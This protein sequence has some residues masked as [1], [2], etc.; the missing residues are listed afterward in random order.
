MEARVYPG[1]VRASLPPTTTIDQNPDEYVAFV[2]ELEHAAGLLLDGG[3][4][5]H[6]M[7]LVIIDSLAERLLYQHAEKCFRAS[8]APIAA[9]TD[10]FPA[11]RRQRTLDDFRR[12]VQLAQ[13]N[14]KFFVFV[15]P[16]LD[17]LDAEI[18]RVAHDY[19]GPGYHR[20][21][22]NPALGRPL[23]CL[24]AQAV[25]R[26]FS[27]SM[28]HSFS[29]ISP[30]AVRKLERFRPAGADPNLNWS[31]PRDATRPITEAITKPLT[32]DAKHLARQLRADT[33]RRLRV[34]AAEIEGLRR[35]LP[36]ERI[37]ELVEAAQHWAQHRGDAELHKLAREEQALEHRAEE[38]ENAV[39]DELMKRLIENR[40]AQFRRM[41]EL[42]SQTE[43]RVDLETFGL[44][45]R[46]ADRLTEKTAITPLLHAYG[47]LDELLQILETA[48]EWVVRSWDQ[49]VQHAIDEA[50]GK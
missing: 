35:D 30:E 21:E 16:I 36:E 15:D 45:H 29:D 28:T 31:L 18:F 37:A 50:R 5:E 25:G 39:S 4:A 34:V 23:G 40:V 11:V 10:P 44:L 49:S 7:A 9:F 27:R 48:M 22:H 17:E 8:E 42:K 19:R 41:E 47:E 13:T 14:E 24:Y 2:E 43:V 1:W 46:R 33:D 12:R 6:R 38:N 20:G 3:L 26:A 32:V